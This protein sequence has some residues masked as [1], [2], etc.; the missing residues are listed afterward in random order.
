MVVVTMPSAVTIQA[1]TANLPGID[2]NADTVLRESFV[3]QWVECGIMYLR[4]SNSYLY[5]GVPRRFR[6][7]QDRYLGRRSLLQSWVSLLNYFGDG[8]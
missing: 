3:A 7:N 6:G 5:S 2:E 8:A 1:R 4:I